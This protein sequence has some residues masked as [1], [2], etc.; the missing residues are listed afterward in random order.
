MEIGQN[1]KYVEVAA[2]EATD[3]VIPKD[4]V[5]KK[6]RKVNSTE[7]SKKKSKLGLVSY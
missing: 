2:K 6:K 7:P 4:V 3:I 5:I 1:E